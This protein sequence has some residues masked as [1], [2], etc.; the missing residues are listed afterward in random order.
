MLTQARA[1]LRRVTGRGHGDAGLSLME[2]IVTGV[3]MSVVMSMALTFFVQFNHSNSALADE[4]VS[5]A[6]A[7]NVLQQ[8][9]ATLRLADSPDTPGSPNGRIVEITPTEIKFYADLGNRDLCST[10][11]CSSASKPTEVDYSLNSDHQLV[12]SY[13]HYN[14][15]TGT[16]PSAPTS[17]S[18]V[19]TGVLTAGWLFV[20]Y[21]DTDPPSAT[22]PQ[23]C[24]GGAGLCGSAAATVLATVV[25]VDISFA[26]AANANDTLQSFTATAALTRGSG[27]A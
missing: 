1:R 16:Y 7:R 17:T 18:V 9:A 22:R 11:S 2:L 19:A 12:E 25:R 15:A 24:H 14:P 26:I 27:V 21:V 6:A 4:N 13:Y 10:G 23:S 8:W 20:P 3:L 5:T